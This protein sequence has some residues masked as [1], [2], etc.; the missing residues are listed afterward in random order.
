MKLLLQITICLL[1]STGIANA[2]KGLT[3]KQKE[4]AKV[5]QDIFSPDE[6][7]TFFLHYEKRMDDMG[8]FGE[9]RDE[10]YH[11]LYYRLYKIKRL[12]DKDS[13]LSE[14]EQKA[15]FEKHVAILNEDMAGLLDGEQYKIHLELWEGLRDAVYRR[16][17]W[18][19]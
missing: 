4:R 15:Q 10:Y 14:M 2:Q 11:I 12:D 16:R 18:N 9:K 6:K 3:A 19:K 13:G 8:L 17:G 5:A 1:M 7:D